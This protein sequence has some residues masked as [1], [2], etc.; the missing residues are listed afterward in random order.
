MENQ[1]TIV[2]PCKNEEALIANTLLILDNQ[3][4]ID[5][6]RVIIADVSTDK[7]REIIQS[8]NVRK[9]KVEIIEGG[10]PSIARNNGAKLA[11]TPYILFLDAD[12]FLVN[13][14]IIKDCLELI[15]TKSLVTCKIRTNGNYS[16]IFPVFEWFRNLFTWHTPC[17]IGGFM[18]FNLDAFKEAGGFDENAKIA[19]D[20]LLSSKIPPS[21]F[22][23]SK[24][25]IYTTERR[26]EKKGVSYMVR[27]MFLSI[28]NKNNK[29]FFEND[30]KYW[31]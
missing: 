27:I 14:E 23:I 8:T 4:N 12:M 20:Y 16:F 13:T 9:I 26:F 18:M 22:A 1:L 2:I 25:K 11:E 28:L 15:K 29:K 6:V 3:V 24:H 21:K 19:E 31:L 7:T 10:L 5:N 30:H 17:A